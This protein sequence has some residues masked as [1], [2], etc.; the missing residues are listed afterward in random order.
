MS[1]GNAYLQGRAPLTSWSR[2]P[3]MLSEADTFQFLQSRELVACNAL[4]WLWWLKS[5]GVRRISA[6]PIETLPAVSG[7]EWDTQAVLCHFEDRIE[8]WAMGHVRSLAMRKSEEV[9]SLEIWFG[10]SLF[11]ADTYLHVSTVSTSIS[12]SLV[13]VD[14]IALDKKMRSELRDFD[15]FGLNSPHSRGEGEWYFS[16]D[17]LQDEDGD[18]KLPDVPADRRMLDAHSM[19]ITLWRLYGALRNATHPK[20]EGNL[21]MTLDRSGLERL[22]RFEKWIEIWAERVQGLSAGYTDWRPEILEPW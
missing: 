16:R 13:L 19:L 17:Q 12:D 5:E 11:L 1:Y 10:Q 15:S 8:V 22:D 2:H 3:L 18:S 6:G 20:D 4:E 7:I 9:H 14:W 21:Y